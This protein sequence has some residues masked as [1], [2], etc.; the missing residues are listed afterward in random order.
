MIPSGDL[1]PQHMK[2]SLNA[3]VRTHRPVGDFLT[4]CLS[5]KLREAVA[6]ADENNSRMLDHIIGYMWNCL[7]GTC[8]GSPEKISEWCHQEGTV[9]TC[10]GCGERFLAVH[11]GEVPCGICGA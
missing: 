5:N 9:L 3:Y 10:R 7:P 2:E 11:D 8:W 1:C 6:Y 4:A